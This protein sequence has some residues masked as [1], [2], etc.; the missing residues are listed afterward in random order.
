MQDNSNEKEVRYLHPENQK[1]L[2]RYLLICRN[3]GLTPK[4]IDAFNIDIR[5]FLNFI[6]NKLINET[7]HID[8]EDFFS[9]CITERK[10]GDWAIARKYVSLN[11]FYSNMIKKEYLNCRNPM[12]KIDRV[13]VRKRQR[14]YLTEEEMIKLFDYLEK[15]NKLREL[16]MISLLF[17][18]GIRLSELY[19]LNR[20]SFDFV[21][22]TFGI[23]GKGDK[24][25][26]A[27]FDEYAEAN[28]K[29]YLAT[30]T[31]NHPAFLYSRESN[32]LSRR[33]IQCAIFAV[34]K[35]AGID[36]D[37]TTHN[38][39]HSCCNFLLKKGVPINMI[40]NVLGHESIATTEIYTHDN[41]W[42]AQAFITDNLLNENGELLSRLEVEMSDNEIDQSHP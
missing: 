14:V 26:T 19:Q 3:K 33:A 36:K 25:R 35:S 18:S 42:N 8:V 40:K 21:H 15:N 20:D 10:N 31:D 11:C 23:T 16:A 28:I 13:K 37:I 32:R 17:S 41:I 39:R 24:F 1:L 22:N 30:R 4:S 9:Y 5:L 27:V 29:K 12:D 34:V 6:G 2:D 7:N 38:L